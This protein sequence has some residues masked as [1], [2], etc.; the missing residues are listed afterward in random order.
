MNEAET[1]QPLTLESMMR[2]EMDDSREEGRKEEEKYERESREEQT[3]FILFIRQS[4]CWILP[5]KLSS[6][7]KSEAGKSKQQRLII[8]QI[9]SR[10]QGRPQVCLSPPTVALSRLTSPR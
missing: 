2:G 3:Q 1:N 7:N 4:L 6:R 9:C 10:A 5:A 8:R